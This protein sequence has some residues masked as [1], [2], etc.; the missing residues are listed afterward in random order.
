MN[1]K[2]IDSLFRK[3]I[4]E[5][6]FSGAQI[7]LGKG[8]ERIF[9]QHYGTTHR[10]SG[11]QPVDQKTLFD[12]ASLTKVVSS[13]CLAMSAYQQGKL[14]LEVPIKTYLP[15][16]QGSPDISIEQ[17]LAH[18]SGLPDW[19]PL[20]QDFKGHGLSYSQIKEAFI[21]KISQIPLKQ[22]P[23]TGRLYS[24]LGFI[25]LGF[26][27]EEIFQARLEGLFEV[28]VAQK[29]GLKNTFFNPLEKVSVPIAATENCPWRKR[30]LIGEVHDDNAWIL[31]GAAGHAGLF[32]CAL[33]LEVWIRAIFRIAQGQHSVL[34]QE[35]FNRFSQFDKAL[36]LA[37]DRV[38]QPKSAAG[39]YF[40]DKTLGHLAFT[41]CSLWM[42]F[43]DKKYVIL[44]TNR[45][46]PHR[47]NSI[48][49]VFRP[50]IHDLLLENFTEN[51][52]DR[53]L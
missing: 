30:L 15:S 42:D 35:T 36:S 17:L 28:E 21:Q 18:T 25:L 52:L 29:Y 7:L 51:S 49:Q 24:D 37:W 33:D 2:K 10:E 53:N 44:L 3:A 39:K 4:E 8:Q 19:A 16:W 38:S 46:Y 20:Y 47:E 13:L 11:F 9:Y 23:G 40:S 6:G 22:A 34:S 26:I 32:S 45:V 41:G 43:S 1:L 27:L 14:K 50:Q 12:M 5:Q 31:G 48:I